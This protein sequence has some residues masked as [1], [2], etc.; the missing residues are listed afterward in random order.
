MSANKKNGGIQINDKIESGAQTIA[1]KMCDFQEAW[2]YGDT[3]MNNELWFKFLLPLSSKALRSAKSKKFH[4]AFKTLLG[5]LLFMNQDNECWLRDQEV[6]SEPKRFCKFFEDFQSGW[7]LVWGQPDVA[8][9]INGKARQLLKVQLQHLQHYVNIELKVFRD[10]DIDVELKI[11]GMEDFKLR[12]GD[13]DDDDE[14]DEDDDDDEEGGEKD[15]EDEW[16]D[17]EE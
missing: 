8:L 12:T 13:D 4:D 17:I 1:M 5:L 14:E 11:V 6:Y 15:E 9:G 3:S 7:V 10:F 2:Q 16:E